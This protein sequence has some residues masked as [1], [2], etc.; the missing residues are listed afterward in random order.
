MR[1]QGS[2]EQAGG[3]AYI[4][5]LAQSHVSA[6]NAE[7]YAKLVRDKSIQRG[8]IEA[9]AKI[10]STG[11][12]TSKDLAGLID[13]AEQSVM[14]VS[15]RT[16]SG[17]F[18]P[19]QALVGDVVDA[20]LKPA[21]GGITGLATGYPELDAI[22]RGLQPSDLI[23]IAARPAMGKT[24]LALNLAMRAAIS[25]G[26][27]V[28][29]FS[30]EMS[31]HQ[32]VQ[33]MISLWGKIPQEQLS[34]GRLSKA[35]GARFFET[36]DLLRTAPLFINETPAIST[37]ELRS[38][39]RRLKA[40]HGLGLIVV[41]YLQLMRS[42]RRTD[43]R[44]LEI[45]DISRSLKA[46]AKELDVPVV[47]LSQLNR[48]VEERKDNRPMLSDLRESGAIEQDADIVIFLYRDGY[49]SPIRRKR[50]HE[51]IIGKHRN[52]RVRTVKWLSC[53]ST[54]PSNRLPRIADRRWWIRQAYIFLRIEALGKGGFS[55][56]LPQRCHFASISLPKGFHKDRISARSVLKC[57]PFE[58]RA[59]LKNNAPATVSRGRP[60]C[61]AC[62]WK[63]TNLSL[64]SHNIDMG[65]P[66]GRCS[67]I[68][69]GTA[70]SSVFHLFRGI[71]FLQNI[72]FIFY[73]QYINI[74]SFQV[75]HKKQ[76]YT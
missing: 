37:L 52:G 2:L 57:F 62:F 16:S 70:P 43:S 50:H 40:E 42:S 53:R 63:C 27:P 30:L 56:P 58:T 8:L 34:T 11:F 49:T 6:A 61:T 71:L 12:D 76:N 75:S 59:R 35:E 7:Y 3:A 73:F 38:Q 47:A 21:E 60:Q 18:R 65:L 31:E 13:E 72:N 9:G 64:S 67:R 46:I 54:P 14:A 41:D 44:E 39:A 32:L 33:R 10:V 24:A 36:A 26:A 1:D 5:D 17:G 45:S 68:R 66:D 22:T 28:G 48:K 4:A 69:P 74:Y 29:I 19:V 20:V 55:A 15:S 51:L 25:E 23:I